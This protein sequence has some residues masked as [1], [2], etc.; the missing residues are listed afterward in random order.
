MG[1]KLAKGGECIPV[2]QLVFARLGQ[3]EDDWLRVALYV[4]AT[5]EAEPAAI[6]RALGLA[7]PEKARE[8]L[9]YWKGAGLLEDGDGGQAPG[10]GDIAAAASRARLTTPQVA[11]AAQADPALRDLLQ[12]CQAIWGGV[13]G[14]GDA[15]IFASLYASDGFPV[16]L[17]LLC[18]AHCAALGKRSARYVESVLFR[19]QRE[20]IATAEA[21]ERH[22]DL[23]AKRAEH[24]KEA[25]AALGLEEAGLTK[26]ERRAIDAWF[27]QLGYDGPMI[28]EAAASAGE[29]KSVRYV[30]GILRKWHAGGLRT[31]KDVLD[32]GRGAMQNLQ[33]AGPAARPV[34]RGKARRAPTFHR[35]GEDG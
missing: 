24:H 32:A 19:W 5:G 16:D 33:P 23:L 31:V 14:Q 10:G 4:I 27:E 12:E 28:T 11:A 20:G 18:T 9:L 25:A 6:A 7:G 34:L 29:K 30:G 13:V 3:L 22:L 15:N 17:I 2:P 21:A 1:Y 8:A 26:A 35:K